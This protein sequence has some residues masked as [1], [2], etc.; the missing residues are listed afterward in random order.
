M[1]VFEVSFHGIFSKNEDSIPDDSDCVEDDQGERYH[2]CSDFCA[3]YHGEI[4][5]SE[6]QEHRS[7]ISDESQG[8]VLYYGV[9]QRDDSED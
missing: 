2:D 1:E 5:E 3:P 6:R 4:G 8:F 7:H 9:Y